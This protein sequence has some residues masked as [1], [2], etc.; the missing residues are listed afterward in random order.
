[1]VLHCDITQVTPTNV[2]GVRWTAHD[3]AYLLT[4]VKV[5]L[6]GSGHGDQRGK[7]RALADYRQGRLLRLAH[8]V[9][10]IGFD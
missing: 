6:V 4:A 10:I 1:M 2:A 5:Q 9:T 3:Q 7:C 8:E